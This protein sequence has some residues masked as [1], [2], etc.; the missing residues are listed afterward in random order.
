MLVAPGA[1]QAARDGRRVRLDAR[2]AELRQH[3]AVPF[4]SH[5]R[6]HDPLAG[7]AHDVAQ[8]VV[9]LHV[10]LRQRFLHVLHAAAAVAGRTR[11]LA[12][13]GAQL[14]DAVRWPERALEQS[15]THQLADPLAVQNVALATAHLLRRP[16]IDQ[17]HLQTRPVENLE[18]RDPVHT[19]RLQ[20][21][22][23]HAAGQQPRRHRLQII[24]EAAKRLYRTLRHRLVHRHVVRG[25]PYVDP[26]AV[27]VHHLHGPLTPTLVS[28]RLVSHNALGRAR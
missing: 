24:R 4:A 6:A 5:H 14:A 19:S 8:H 20:C 27:R 2:I 22:Q 28:H 9:E 10:H 17:M 11:A 23:L 7:H 16:C 3:R 13:V 18:H 15:V 21:D 26:R 1:A 25:L 12:Y